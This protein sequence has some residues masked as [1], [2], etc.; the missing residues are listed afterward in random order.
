MSRQRVRSVSVGARG[1][2][3]SARRTARSQVLA[4][5]KVR[6]WAAEFVVSL[7]DGGAGGGSGDAHGGATGTG[8]A[9]RRIDVL[10][11]PTVPRAAAPLRPDAWPRGESDAGLIMETTRHIFLANLI[12][13]PAITVPVGRAAT[14]AGGAADTVARDAGEALPAAPLPLGFQLVGAPWGEAAL[15]RL[16]QAVERDAPANATARPRLFVD[17]LASA[18]ELSPSA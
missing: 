15:L 8:R 1:A 17:V 5:D 11:L 14:T 18:R 4:A 3:E 10:A 12:G 13:V 6:A 9:P 7:F 2:R 16:A